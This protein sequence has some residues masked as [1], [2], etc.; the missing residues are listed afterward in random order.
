MR[1]NEEKW[2]HLMCFKGNECLLADKKV[3]PS[4]LSHQIEDPIE[5][6]TDQEE[7]TPV[8]PSDAITTTSTSVTISITSSTST[9]TS[10]SISTS[11]FI[12]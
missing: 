11:K 10:T 8:R 1:A 9:S 12:I 3:L 4:F 7:S 5:C 6:M 2:A